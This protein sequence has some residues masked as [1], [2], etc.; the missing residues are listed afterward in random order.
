[1]LGPYRRTC[2]GRHVLPWRYCGALVASWFN[3]TLAALDSWGA[4][5]LLS[6]LGGENVYMPFKGEPD[7]ADSLQ[8]LGEPLVIECILDPNVIAKHRSVDFGGIWLSSLHVRVNP[9]AHRF[10]QDLYMAVSVPP[11]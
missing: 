4:D 7:I 8:S 3:M 10:D 5:P 11:E 1:M 6:H 2:F 9:S